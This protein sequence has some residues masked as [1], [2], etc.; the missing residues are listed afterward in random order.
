M[1]L[2]KEAFIGSRNSL[3]SMKNDK[4]WKLS[5]VAGKI[6][7]FSKKNLLIFFIYFL[8]CRNTFTNRWPHLFG[9]YGY[10]SDGTS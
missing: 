2:L 5:S 1:F 10:A 9:C 6:K 3:S 7:S 4:G 8:F